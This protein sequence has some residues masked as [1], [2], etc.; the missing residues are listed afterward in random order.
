MPTQLRQ[1]PPRGSSID[2]SPEV[3]RRDHAG[4]RVRFVRQRSGRL[5]A[6]ARCDTLCSVRA[7]GIAA[8]GFSL[9][10]FGKQG[11]LRGIAPSGFL[12]GSGSGYN[13][14]IRPAP[15]RLR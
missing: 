6:P 9:S 14:S 12:T 7:K 10:D 5:P 4:S 15:S 8:A 13:A 3:C 1:N 11:F 2:V